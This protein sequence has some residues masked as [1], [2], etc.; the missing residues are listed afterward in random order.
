V[1]VADAYNWDPTTQL[2][3][4]DEADILGVEACLWS[5]TILS[6]K[7]L[8]YMV[9]PRLPGAA[10]IGWTSRAGR[11]WPDYCQRLAAH[12]KRLDAMQVN[13]YHS[14]QVPWEK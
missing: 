12:G 5:E 14:L 10:E 2:L 7:D 4:V 8:E 13:Y 6:I 9:F 1:E 3:G 11:S